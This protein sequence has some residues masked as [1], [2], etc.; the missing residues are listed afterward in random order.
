MRIPLGLKSARGSEAKETSETFQIQPR[1]I[2]RTGMG[3]RNKKSFGQSV[4]STQLMQEWRVWQQEVDLSEPKIQGM[5]EGRNKPTQCHL[6]MSSWAESFTAGLPEPNT[7]P[8]T[9]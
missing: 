3:L 8:G 7:V 1:C 6:A 9:H 4:A 5:G 2:F